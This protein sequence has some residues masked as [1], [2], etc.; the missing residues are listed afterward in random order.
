[1]TMRGWVA[2]GLVAVTAGAGAPADACTVIAAGRRATADGSVIVSQTDTA[3]DSRIR[4][5]A[6]RTH[7]PGELAPVYWGLL[8]PAQP[9]DAP[10]EV[11]GHVPQAA[12]TFTYVHAA[13]SF[14]NEHQLAIAESTTVQRPELA[15]AKGEGE[16]IMTIE[17]A[18]VFALQRCTTAREAVRLI[19][20]LMETYG[21]LPSQDGSEA[22]AIGDPREV[23]IFE[24][25]SVGRGW[26]RASGRPGAIWAAQ[27][28]GDDQ[29]TVIPNW[30]VIREVDLRDPERFLASSNVVQEAVAR[31]WYD[32]AAGRPF[33][34]RD[35]Y[36][37]IPQEFA[38]GRFWLFYT[39]IAPRLAAWP[40]RWLKGDAAKGLNQY[41]QYVEPLSIYP[42]SAP[43]ESRITVRDVIA[44]Q[45][46]T[47]E[48]TIYDLAGGPQ[49]LVPDAKGGLVRSPLATPFPSNELRALLK[50]TNRRP[51]ARHRGHYGFVAQ[52]REWLPA[53]VGGVSWV[54]L[55]N[56]HVSAYVP[57]Y[58]GTT[59]VSPAYRTYHPERF[60]EGSARWAIDVV[61]NLANLRFQDAIQDVRAARDPFEDRLFAAQPDVDREAARLSRT[62]DSAAREYVTR[63]TRQAMDDVMA[64]FGELRATLFVKYTNNR[65]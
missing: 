27:R 52:L 32:P 24:V 1:M 37:P 57:V 12:R 64:L 7:Q 4:I 50:L 54:Y 41:M 17:Q 28:L 59:D 16:Q 8:D 44:L 21:F 39:T 3:A 65:Q 40:D 51:V 33:S 46:S 2:I 6:G 43:P 22:L 49:W 15:V 42:F 36:T 18:Q 61:D 60:D 19:G 29:A 34:L 63:L 10:V 48:G 5:V 25:F 56:P 31:G 38:T 35:A 13:Y 62:S 9:A 14:M 11:L 55:D 20:S 53:A 45:R 47:F 23:W 30:S 58:A 26:T